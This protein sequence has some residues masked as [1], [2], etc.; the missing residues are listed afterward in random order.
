MGENFRAERGRGGNSLTKVFVLTFL[1]V[2]GLNNIISNKYEI[3]AITFS[4][5]FFIKNKNVF[6]KLRKT[7]TKI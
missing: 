3:L 4:D 5:I 6:T 7:K 2:S 1:K